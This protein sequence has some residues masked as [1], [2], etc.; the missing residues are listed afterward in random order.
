TKRVEMLGRFPLPIEVIPFG[1]QVV[2]EKVRALGAG[3]T[4]REREGAPFLT[5]N[6]GYILDC[7]FGQIAHPPA[8][9]RQ[10]KAITGV[11]ETGLFIAMAEAAY[12]A[13]GSQVQRIEPAP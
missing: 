8:L 6:Q 3:V 2:A 13:E 10:L 12:V 1:W 11:T 4:L 7:T 5:D 9:E